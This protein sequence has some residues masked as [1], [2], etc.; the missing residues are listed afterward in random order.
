[1]DDVRKI[2][3]LTNRLKTE[4]ALLF[5]WIFE[6]NTHYQHSVILDFFLRKGRQPVSIPDA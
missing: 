1:M 4:E 6:G 2:Y 5:V 3:T